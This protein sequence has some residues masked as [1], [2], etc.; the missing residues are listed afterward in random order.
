MTRLVLGDCLAGMRRMEAP[1][2]DLTVTSPPYGTLRRFGGNLLSWDLFRGVADELWRLTKPGG[3]LCWQEGDHVRKE[4]GRSGVGGYS[5]PSW[6]HALHLQRLGFRI[7]D[8]LI[9]G[10]C[11]VRYPTPLRY[12]RPP[13]YLFVLSK[14]RPRNVRLLRDRPNA[15]AGAV[16]HH[17]Q[18]LEDGTVLVRPK[19]VI[20]QAHGVRTTVWLYPIAGHSPAGQ[21]HPAPMHRSL[22]WDL[23]RTYSRQGDLVFDPFAGSCTTGEMAILSGRD[24]LGFEVYEP[25]H[26]IGLRRLMR[27]EEAVRRG[28]GARER[29]RGGRRVRAP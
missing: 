14:G 3:V 2:F 19:D 8:V 4:H 18:R 9:T 17:T 13:V 28:G 23:I 22:A 15:T 25:Y 21:K 10:A 27:A 12:R 7:W 20:V 24:F 5:G 1:L 16:F 11:G 29:G 26:E 6:R